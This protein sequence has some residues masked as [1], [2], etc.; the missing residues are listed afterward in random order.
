MILQIPTG[1]LVDRYGVKIPYAISFVVWCLA[2]A[3]T[4]LTRSVGELT[5]LRVITGAGGAIVTPASF[6]WMRQHSSEQQSG[7]AV[8]VYMLGSKI[9][10]AIGAPI[11]AWLITLYDW[12]LMFIIVGLAGLIWLG[13][14]LLMV[15]KDPPTGP[16]GGRAEG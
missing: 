13:P 6:R 3:A 10:P 11:A 9:G 1:C 12:H 4:G 15:K 7:L 8:G 16:V 2:S 5:S 14:W